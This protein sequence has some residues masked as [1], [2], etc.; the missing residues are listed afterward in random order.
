MQCENF[1]IVNY[2]LTNPI[3]VIDDKKTEQAEQISPNKRIMRNKINSMRI[4]LGIEQIFIIINPPSLANHCCLL[5]LCQI[6]KY[7]ASVLLIC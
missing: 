1:K 7:L 2:L 4:L 3:I 5:L 6:H